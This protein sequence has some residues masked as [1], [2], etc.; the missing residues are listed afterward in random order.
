M[1]KSKNKNRRRRDTSRIANKRLP[2][3]PYRRSFARKPRYVTQLRDV[4]GGH[5]VRRLDL[6][7]DRRQWHP[8]GF[9]RSLRTVFGQPSVSYRVPSLTQRYRP[10]TTFRSQMWTLPAKVGFK[11]PNKVAVCVRR[12]QRREVLFAKHKT[13]RSGQKRPRWNWF[14]RITCRR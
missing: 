1:A 13:G 14:S 3:P 4:I 12:K 7:E 2:P 9:N 10:F 5:R 11:E 6:A 8:D